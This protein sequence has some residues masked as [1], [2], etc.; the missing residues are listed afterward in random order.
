MT[1]NIT[2]LVS[3]GYGGYPMSGDNA[4][5]FPGGGGRDTLPAG[6]LWERIAELDADNPTHPLP[7]ERVDPNQRVRM[8]GIY[9]KFAAGVLRPTPID[10][11]IIR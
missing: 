5:T 3:D 8:F 9:Q 7:A 4:V 6:Q 10:S 11:F 1:A 2:D